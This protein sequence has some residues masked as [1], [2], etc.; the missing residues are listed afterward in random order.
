MYAI[1]SYYEVSIIDEPTSGDW[2]SLL[3]QSPVFQQIP[4]ANLQRVMMRMEEIQVSAGDVI[5]SQGDDGDYFYLISKGEC[6]VTRTPE[7]GHAPVELAKLRVGKGF[8]EEALIS[9]KPRSSSVT[10]LTDGILVRLN[11]QDFIDLVKQPP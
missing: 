4:P 5:I 2:M 10:M 8:G 11:K 1:R 6:S 9:D 7:A 3:L